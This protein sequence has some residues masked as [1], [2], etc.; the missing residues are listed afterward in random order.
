MDVKLLYW[1]R[2]WD[3][4]SDHANAKVQ[5]EYHAYCQLEVCVRGRILLI[6]PEK[7]FVLHAGDMLLIPN[8]IGHLVRY[9]EAANEFYS[10]KFE[11]SQ[12]P[13][14]AQFISK[15]KF[16]DWLIKTLRECHEPQA[17]Y[18][19]PIDQN[20]RELVE[21]ILLLS[22]KKFL[23]SNQPLPEQEPPLFRRIRQT[24]LSCGTC[25]NVSE[26][27]QKLQ[28]NAAQLN[29]Q[30]S[31]ELR[32]YNLS[33]QEYSVKKIIDEALLYLINRHLDF[34]DFP[35]H[36]IARQMKF[37]NVY[38][39]SR[40]YKRLTGAAPRNRRQKTKSGQ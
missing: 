36:I 24:V 18:F 38:T 27:A 11:S 7:E 5:F 3:Q 26:C 29:Y 9:P 34:T 28:M 32:E 19:M 4:C 14:K 10:L 25:I 6:L 23:R 39:F 17:R 1:G 35:L 40:Y 37:N 13:D 21:G 8:G 33:M 30:F 22:M 31:K 12:A 16:T 2:S 15:S 20:S